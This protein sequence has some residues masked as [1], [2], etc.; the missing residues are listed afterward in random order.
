MGIIKL[1]IAPQVRPL[2]RKLKDPKAAWMLLGELNNRKTNATRL[3]AINRFSMIK[4]TKKD[5]VAKFVQRS[6]ELLNYPKSLLSSNR[7]SR[8][9][10]GI[11]TP[12]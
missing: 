4:M 11:M 8:D 7:S 3:D 6:T 10:Q 1:T 12:L 2:I 9:F 5:F